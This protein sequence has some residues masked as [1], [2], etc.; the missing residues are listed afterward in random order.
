MTQSGP[1]RNKMLNIRLSEDEI[2]NLHRLAAETGHANLSSLVREWASQ[3]SQPPVKAPP[4]PKYGK[5]KVFWRSGEGKIYLGDSLG[6]LHRTLEPESVD[7]VVTSPPFGLV[8]QKAYGNEPAHRYL[9]WFKPFAEGIKRVLKPSG[10]LVID[11]GPA[12]LEGVPAKSLYQFQL[13]S[14][15]CEEFG[16][17]LAQDFYWWNPCRMP[18]PAEWVNIRRLRVK[19]SVNPVWWLSPTPW[20]KASNKRVLTAYGKDQKKLFQNGYNAGP[21]PSG[22]VVSESWG[23]DNGGAIP[24]NLIAAPNTVSD[25]P[26]QKFCREMG[27]NAHPARFPWALPDFFIKMLTNAGDLV[28]DPFAGSCMTG[29]VAAAHHRKW[30]CCELNEDYLLGALGR[31]QADNRQVAPNVVPVSGYSVPPQQAEAVHADFEIDRY[32]GKPPPASK[33]K[34]SKA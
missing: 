8:K 33:R 34:K 28:V 32:G 4:P 29:A 2:A 25:D 13:L 14:M 1:H 5:P 15:L 23:R 10:S 6:L 19:D 26:Y 27:V 31:F 20:P 17:Y 9:D 3:Q 30:I 22:H 7:L 12:W 16:F 24:P 11:I 18:A 21:R